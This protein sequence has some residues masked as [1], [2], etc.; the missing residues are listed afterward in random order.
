MGLGVVND[1]EVTRKT[2]FSLARFVYTALL[3]PNTT[4]SDVFC[5]PGT[6]QAP[7]MWEFYG[8]FQGRREGAEVRVTFL[9]LLPLKLLQLA[10]AGVDQW[11]EHWL[12]NQNVAGSVP[13]QGT[14]LGCCQIPGWGRCISCTSMFLTLSFSVPSHLS[15]NK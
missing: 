2:R 8:P 3:A 7:F 4:S 13:S 6:G 5:P 9:L 10:L 15:K 14:G 11:I 1:E 12:V